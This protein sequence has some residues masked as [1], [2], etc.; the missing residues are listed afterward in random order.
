[1]RNNSVIFRDN[2]L[3]DT[4]A[5]IYIKNYIIPPIRWIYNLYEKALFSPSLEELL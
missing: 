3:Y 5:T 2:N 4:V 1:M